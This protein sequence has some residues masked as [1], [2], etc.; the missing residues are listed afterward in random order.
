MVAVKVRHPGVSDAIERDF[1][2]MVA[3]AGVLGKLPALKALRLEESLAQFAAPLREQVDLAREGFYLRAF[4]YNFRKEARVSF[5][6]PLYP[7]VAPSVLVESFERGALVSEYVARGA[8]APH[9]SALARVGAR[10]ML[11]MLIVDN[12]VGRGRS[13]AND[14]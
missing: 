1:A 2:L 13:D 4:S 14:E 9:N 5:P 3:A 6:V 11:H 12:L 10:A 7:L 8:G